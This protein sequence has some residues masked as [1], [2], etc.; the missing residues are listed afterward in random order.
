M[1]FEA[2][3]ILNER[4]LAEGISVSN[5]TRQTLLNN[6][7]LIIGPSGSGKTGGY[8]IPNLL[9][10]QG[11]IMVA[12]T[13][14][15]LRNQL[16][17]VL[18]SRGYEVYTVDFVHPDRSSPYNPLDYITVDDD[19]RLR[20]QDIM[21]IAA[22]I[23]TNLD[24]EEPFWETSARTVMACL[25]AYV[26]EVFPKDEQNLNT[27]SAV[28]RV[29]VNQYA[30]QKNNNVYCIPFL[31]E[32]AAV[33]PDS[34]C[35]K[36]YGMFK[37]SL[38]ADRTWACITQFVSAAID[39]FDFRQAKALF[40]GKPDFQFG[41]LGHKKT[42]VFLNISDTDRT[43]DRIINLFY[44]PYLPFLPC[45]HVAL[46]SDFW[47]MQPQTG[48]VAKSGTLKVISNDDGTK[49]VIMENLKLKNVE[50]DNEFFFPILDGSLQYT[51]YMYE[52]SL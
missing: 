49:T 27:V 45:V 47:T 33:K 38:A 14:S 5:D 48:Y 20:D 52:L 12:D 30:E 36:K 40:G 51:G 43:L 11:S 50:H 35:A 10:A 16:G 15:N 2:C 32:F 25:I 46:D 6:N 18:E 4:P 23:V 37:G 9:A 34:F 39:V 13:K 26:K 42:A 19:G 44:T 24:K 21:T 7:D 3:R 28:F 8:V 17:P 31:E 41:D 29:M 22:A 1:K